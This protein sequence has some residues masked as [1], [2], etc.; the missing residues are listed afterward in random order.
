[1]P[2]YEHVHTDCARSLA[3]LF[4][5]LG[6]KPPQGLS[7]VGIETQ[8]SS[9]LPELRHSLARNALLRHRAT[10][11]LWVDSD[12]AFPRDAFHRL[13]AHDREI[14]GVTYP[15]RVAPHWSSATDLDGKPFSPAAVG[16]AEAGVM[17]FGLLLTRCA[18]FEG[19]YEMPLF[20]HHDEH[21]YCTEDVTFARKVRERGYRLW[22][23]LDLSRE[24]RHASLRWLGSDQMEE[25][26]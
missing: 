3:M 1:M 22:C 21:G 14:V 25:Q 18:V 20:A 11:I 4:L 23:D 10:H 2:A 6:V 13:L 24:V 12:M 15:R 26:S 7:W 16:I 9:N 8:S 17:G 5:E 19:E